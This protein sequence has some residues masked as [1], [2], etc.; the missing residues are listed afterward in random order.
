V[1]FAIV[2]CDYLDCGDVTPLS[3]VS[4]SSVFN[5]ECGVSTPLS[6]FSRLTKKESG[7]EPPH[8]TEKNQERKKAALPRRTPNSK[9]PLPSELK[10]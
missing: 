2:F 4:P 10:Q 7:V 5:L 1:N 9:T 6:F 3:F 8:S